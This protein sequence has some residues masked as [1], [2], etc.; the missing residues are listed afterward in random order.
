MQNEPI[1]IRTS[2]ASREDLSIYVDGFL[3]GQA[4]AASLIADYLRT[5]GYEGAN[6]LVAEILEL[7]RYR[8]YS[9]DDVDASSVS[10]P[11]YGR[12]MSTP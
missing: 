5:L 2:Y 11:A 7:K 12:L 9:E 8:F 4:V 10:C 1:E 3:K 6:A